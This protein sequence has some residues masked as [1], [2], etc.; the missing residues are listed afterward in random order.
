MFPS[1]L[2]G[3][4][5]IDGFLQDC[6]PSHPCETAL[7]PRRCCG[8][9][10]QRCETRQMRQAPEWIVP[11]KAP[12]TP[13]KWSKNIRNM[14]YRAA[15]HG[16]LDGLAMEFLKSQ[17]I[18]GQW[19]PS[20]LGLDQC[21]TISVA[22]WCSLVM[23]GE[24]HALPCLSCGDRTLLQGIACEFFFW[25][26]EFLSAETPSTLLNMFQLN[27][28]WIRFTLII[29]CVPTF[30][31]YRRLQGLCAYIHM[32]IVIQCYTYGPWWFPKV[33]VPTNHP[34]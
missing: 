6:N 3:S 33:V 27:H 21:L 24:G 25:A 5:L 29:Y 18:G 26:I 11:V 19:S 15:F 2:L 12:N 34:F 10:P 4:P 32:Y 16:Y 8:F 23:L 14:R 9:W 30:P 20:Y 17:R 7:H 1:F 28:V 31:Y 13:Q 22:S